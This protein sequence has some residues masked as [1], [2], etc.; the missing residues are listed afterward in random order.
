MLPRLAC[1]LPMKALFHSFLLVSNAHGFAIFGYPA[2]VTACMAGT[3]EN[4][5][6][7]AAAATAITG[8][9]CATGVALATTAVVAVCAVACACFDENAT[10]TTPNG[11]LTFNEVAVGEQ[12]LTLASDG[13]TKYTPV[14]NTFRM[15][16]D[17][18][19]EFA[20][21]KT[22]RAALSVTKTQPVIVKQD[23]ANIVKEGGAVAVGDVMVGPEDALAPVT[24][25][26]TFV[27][28]R[29]YMIQTE[30]GTVLADGFLVNTMTADDFPEAMKA[31]R[32]QIGDIVAFVNEMDKDGDTV[33]S[34]EELP[35][36]YFG[37]SSDLET[38]DVNGDPR[39]VPNFLDQE[40]SKVKA[41]AR[42]ADEDGDGSR[43]QEFA[44]ALDMPFVIVDKDHDNDTEVEGVVGHFAELPAS[45][46]HVLQE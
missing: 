20:E 24:S 31:G 43:S 44:T 40:F 5:A 39:L 22:A 23:G 4:L 13:K 35:E 7:A 29:K 27:A 9:A 12:V 18:P 8:P 26:S 17:T 14:L 38:A 10:V 33:L 42:R 25:V 11:Q 37:R 36:V 1:F 45:R 6:P 30:E 15:Q 32:L 28:P 16:K 41:M 34:L 3:G 21:I 2:C 19:F 46:G